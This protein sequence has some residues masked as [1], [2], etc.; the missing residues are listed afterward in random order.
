[1]VEGIIYRSTDNLS[2]FNFSTK[3]FLREKPFVVDP[4]ML[5]MVI[6]MVSYVS[7]I[8]LRGKYLRRI[9]KRFIIE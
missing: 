7:F 2:L 6:I 1:N 3:F 8:T 5:P 9:P 4:W